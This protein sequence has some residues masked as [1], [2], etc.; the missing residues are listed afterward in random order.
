M[1]HFWIGT[2]LLGTLL[3]LSLWAAV[4]LDNVHTPIEQDLDAAA[5][6]V[7]DSDWDTA[8][9][10]TARAEDRWKQ[11]RNKVA[12]LASHSSI[13]EIDSLFRQ[14]EVYGRGR[15]VLVY[16]AACRE[17]ACLAAAISDTHEFTW[18]NLL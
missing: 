10:L 12:A 17:L 16:A 4:A 15:D 1:R 18:W 6:A 14:L 11:D 5:E 8:L 7:L 13:E 9:S 3:G 2:L